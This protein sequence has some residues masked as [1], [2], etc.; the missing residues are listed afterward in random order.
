ME[1]RSR[2][3]FGSHLLGFKWHHSSGPNPE[4]SANASQSVPA[5]RTLKS[6]D[7]AQWDWLWSGYL[8]FYRQHV[9]VELTNR[10]FERLVDET[11]PPYGLVSYHGDRLLGF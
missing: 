6:S 7:R 9:P 3:S 2:L 4:M 11:R 1:R 10:T 8:R 5:V